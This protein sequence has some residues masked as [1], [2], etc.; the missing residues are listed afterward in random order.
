[1]VKALSR[2]FSKL[3]YQTTQSSPHEKCRYL[4]ILIQPNGISSKPFN[5]QPERR[6]W[7]PIDTWDAILTVT[8]PAINAKATITYNIPLF[9]FYLRPYTRLQRIE[10]GPL[11]L[12]LSGLYDGI[13]IFSFQ[14]G[15]IWHTTYSM[16]RETD[17]TYYIY[18]G[19]LERSLIWLI[20]YNLS[21]WIRTYTPDMAHPYPDNGWAEAMKLNGPTTTMPTRIKTR[22]Q[23]LHSNDFC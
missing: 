20:A 22:S 13:L 16:W 7:I 4:L 23:L 11:P 8:T 21:A 12:I 19:P 17:V 10:R 2:S 18:R 15:S 9:Y 3:P 1:M 6:Q 5:I 14:C